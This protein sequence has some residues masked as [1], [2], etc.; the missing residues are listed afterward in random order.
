MNTSKMSE[1]N[2]YQIQVR[3]YKNNFKTEKGPYYAKTI[4]LNT[5][6]TAE[7]CKQAAE[8]GGSNISPA[9]MNQAVEDFF[10]EMA[11]KLESGVAVNTGYFYAH[12]TIKGAFES[13]YDSFDE[14]RHSVQFTFS[15]GQL[16]R[17]K[18]DNV[19]FK[20]LGYS[21]NEPRIETIYDYTTLNKNGIITPARNLKL[22][23]NKI[24]IAGDDE[25][26]ELYFVNTETKVRTKLPK[27]FILENNPKSVIVLCPD[28][29]PGLYT[30]EI[31]TQ[32]A[33][34]SNT[35]K[36]ITTIASENILQV[37]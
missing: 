22:I 8:R 12:P 3:L 4:A 36:T 37:E 34:S 1:K 9:L 16:M 20:I 32:Y 14:T 19:K 21:E 7:I 31:L 15:Q 26:V 29:S 23:G 25:N 5:M 28:L 6:N 18:I 30:L 11:Y 2:P 17:K 24:R 10:R 33:N 13:K 27:E 35:N